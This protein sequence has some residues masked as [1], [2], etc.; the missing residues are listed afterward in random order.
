MTRTVKR[1]TIIIAA[2]LLCAIITAVILIVVLNRKENI[3]IQVSAVSIETDN[4]QDE[5][6]VGQTMNLKG[7]KL[8]V[9]YNSG[10]VKKITLMNSMIS[11]VSNSEVF[12]KAEERIISITYA[13]LTIEKTIRVRQPEIINLKIGNAS[14]SYYWVGEDFNLFYNTVIGVYEDESEKE[15]MITSDMLESYSSEILQTAGQKNITV[16]YEGKT[17]EWQ[18]YVYDRQADYTLFTYSYENDNTAAITGLNENYIDN[19]KD[20]LI[21]PETVTKDGL[22]Y[23][24]NKISENAFNYNNMSEQ[25]RAFFCKVKTV[26]IPKSIISIGK[27]AFYFGGTEN[28]VIS[29]LSNVRFADFNQSKL[30]SIGDYAFSGTGLTNIFIPDGVA[31]IG[32]YAFAECDNIKAVKMSSHIET[33]GKYAFIGAASDSIT[34]PNTIVNIDYAFAESKISLVTFAQGC[35]IKTLIGTFADSA[36]KNVFDIPETAI[37][38]SDIFKN[39]LELKSVSWNETEESQTLIS[40]LPANI[41]AGLVSLEQVKLPSC[42]TVIGNYAFK[43]CVSITNIKLP[44]LISSVSSGEFY[45]CISLNDISFE[46]QILSVN[47]Y[48]FYGCEHLTN[49]LFDNVTNIKISAFESSGLTHINIT[50]DVLKI[51]SR[52]FA[53]CSELEVVTFEE[54]VTTISDEAFADCEKLTAIKFA[55]SITTLGSF[56]FSNCSNL[57]TVE[58]TDNVSKMGNAVFCNCTLLDNVKLSEMVSSI[59][60]SVFY[61][62]ESL[63][64]IEF[65]DI[66]RAIP[67]YA[68]YNCKSLETVKFNEIISTIGNYAFFGTDSLRKVVLPDSVTK[69]G[70]NCFQSGGITEINLPKKISEIGSYAFCDCSD[71]S[72]VVWNENN[73][74]TKIPERAFSWCAS[75]NEI[76]LPESIVSLEESAFD[77]SGLINITL[78]ENLSSIGKYVFYGCLFEAIDIPASVNEIGENAFI[79]CIYLKTVTG[80]GSIKNIGKNAFYNDSELNEFNINNNNVKLTIADMAFYNLTKLEKCNF[81]TGEVNIADYAFYNDENLSSVKGNVTSVGNYSFAH[82]CSLTDFEFAE[83]LK[84]SGKAGFLNSNLYSV[85]FNCDNLIIADSMFERNN[86][87]TSVII[88]GAVTS[89]GQSAFENCENL[90]TFT[91]LSASADPLIINDYAFYN[92]A[93][94]NLTLCEKVSKIGRGAFYNTKLQNIGLSNALTYLGAAAFG[95]CN[96]LQTVAFNSEPEFQNPISIFK[97]CNNIEKIFVRGAATTLFANYFTEYTDC[98][99]VKDGVETTAITIK[100]ISQKKYIIGEP[101]NLSGCDIF[102]ECSDGSKETVAIKNQMVTNFDSSVT[103]NNTV[104]ISYL[105][106]SVQY[107]YKITDEE[108]IDILS[109]FDKS[110]YDIGDAL[111]STGGIIRVHK[112]GGIVEIIEVNNEMVENFYSRDA[113]D[114]LTVNINYNGIVCDYDVTVRKALTISID[115]ISAEHQQYSEVDLVNA[116]LYVTYSNGDTADISL[117]YKMITNSDKYNV[118]G[119]Q[120]TLAGPTEYILK[121]EYLGAAGSTKINVIPSYTVFRSYDGEAAYYIYRT[122]KKTDSW[123]S[124]YYIYCPAFYKGV[125]VVGLAACAYDEL[126][127]VKEFEFSTISNIEW[128]E[129]AAFYMA[130]GSGYADIT[131]IFPKSLKTISYDYCGEGSG[132]CVRGPFAV[133]TG[134]DFKLIF[135]GSL[136]EVVGQSVNAGTYWLDWN[137]SKLNNKSSFS[138]YVQDEDYITAVTLDEWSAYTDAGT[139]YK[140]SELG[141]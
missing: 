89:I 80:G 96:N 104:T 138:I 32:D 35:S 106:F 103:G 38:I 132:Y 127:S 86:N 41:F 75:L 82:T 66:V 99:D 136:P 18:F 10:V 7:V 76:E 84:S 24:V 95:N 81:G 47:D 101:I 60:S 11:G 71:L 111:D 91:I 39:C 135:S 69:L 117:D 30:L 77:A 74:I 110:V 72:S 64:E 17:T 90:N 92:T 88:N 49:F 23:T 42:I 59:G 119:E 8:S 2:V 4:L 1:N 134:V 83:N 118:L 53:L 97:N 125:K 116:T 137:N 100:N 87:L 123:T 50:S 15:I 94:S 45:G 26:D 114:C 98:I 113:T 43:D 122:T 31:N 70:E 140:I 93:L 48:A 124:G 16:S 9:T 126:Y 141:A 68:F 12:D 129:P 3:Q 108:F 61:G 36:V 85:R 128:L 55:D 130:F 28:E 40:S 105:G 79:N 29:L 21:I 54:G 73:T 120:T 5:Y 109:G 133:C 19:Q 63:K 102:A 56:I 44:E 22:T 62:C 65:S 139:I 121:Y 131:I 33:I 57:K 34:V 13:G 37:N 58:M 52:A 67:D 115:S 78:D 112:Q 27:K 46:G 20:T 51:D 107:I 14:G 6:F 25:A